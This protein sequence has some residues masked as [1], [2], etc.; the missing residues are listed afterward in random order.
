[1]IRVL[2]DGIEI[3]GAYI[4]G[5][6][7][8]VE[9]YS[10]TFTIGNTVCQNFSLDIRNEVDP[11]VPDLV[12]LYE[13][14]G[15]DSSENWKL[16]A[17]LLV[18]DVDYSNAVFT[19]YA[20]TDMMVR[21]N[22]NLVYEQGETVLTILNRICENKGIELKT[23]D[24]YM[25]DFAITWQDNITERELISY[26]A[27]VNGGYAYIDE[28]GDL[29]I[30]EYSR[31]TVHTIDAEK[32]SAFTIGAR[33]QISRVYVELAEDTRYYPES[34]GN[35][36][37][38]LNPNNIFLAG[39][40][41]YETDDILRHIHS[42]I[43]GF[44]FYNIFIERCPINPDVRAGQLIGLSNW[45]YLQTSDGKNIMTSGGDLIQVSG[46][47]C[48]CFI[49]TINYDYN[50]GWFGGYELELE[51]KQQQETKIVQAKDLV[52]RLQITVDRE[53]GLIQRSI[54]DI[55]DGVVAQISSVEQRSDGLEARVV[56]NENR[57]TSF[58]TAVTITADGVTITQGTDG[59]YTQF[60]DSGM[61]IYAEGNKVAWA[62]AD[63]FSSEELM[64][65]GASDNE[66]WHMHM[67]NEGKTLMFLRR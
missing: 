44:T 52:K 22:A 60:T 38:Y 24:L 32:C 62:E 54:A 58:E 35:D 20:L 1:M 9:P 42:V 50:D 29:H 57:L 56:R 31:M 47:T 59:S 5:L 27:E 48:A 55:E 53:L 63:G 25:S 43:N 67:A 40:S 6:H 7:Q 49:C 41:G 8:T 16:K 64:I 45:A 11:G 66:K 65:G 34:S 26:V 21:F 61:D 13:D 4:T 10:N 12:C 30:S 36:T 37:L 28:N 15:S 19:T 23:Q 3:N 18:D 17:T 14:N 33:H 51:N 2:F 46:D 39:G